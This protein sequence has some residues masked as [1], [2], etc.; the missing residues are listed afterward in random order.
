MSNQVIR[1]VG[2][3]AV[4]SFFV[5]CAFTPPPNTLGTVREI[6]SDYGVG[7]DTVG[8]NTL[9]WWRTFNDPTLNTLIDTALLANLDLA[10]AVGRLEELRNRYRIAR[11]PLLPSLNVTGDANR[12]DTPGNTGFGGSLGGD[13]ESP[14]DSIGGFPFKF[15]DRF[16]FTTYAASLGFAYEI[17]FWGKLRN[18]KGAAIHDFLAS[19]A[20]LETVRLAVIGSTISTYLEVV[21]TRRQLA[22]AEENEEI[23][24]ERAEL[25]DGRYRAGLATSF[26]L[27]TIR[28][29]YRNAQAELPGARTAIADA[30]GRLAVILGRYAGNLDDLLPAQLNPTVDT[31]PISAGLPVSLLAARP[32]VLAAFERLEAA[33]L[34]LGARRAELLPTI[35][36]NGSAGFQSSDLENLFRVDQW[37]VNLLGGLVSPLF[38][39]GRIRA[40][41]GVADAQYNQL[42]AAYVRTV[43]TAFREVR[44]SLLQLDNERERYARVLEEVEDARASFDYQL[45]RYRRGVGDYLSYL[46][47][48]RNLIGARTTRTQ[49]ERG[50]SEARLGVHRAIG[51]TWIQDQVDLGGPTENRDDGSKD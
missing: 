38:Q 7:V 4:G 26:E 29:Q 43:L 45:R 12:S 33:R 41:I 47:A 9:D 21:A 8:Y 14:T 24:R 37:F 39:G 42:V 1:F 23:L 22:L 44:T 27:Y 46:D 48:R 3:L 36:L 28:Q 10:E 34:R 18:E 15:P 17:D 51:G 50:V 20:D 49:V 25:T 30:E 5:G 16:A 31:D 32:D 40:N 11:A 6:P 13:Q 35:S 19:R 2:V